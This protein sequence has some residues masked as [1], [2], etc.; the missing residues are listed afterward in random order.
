[1]KT[2]AN[3]TVLKSLARKITKENFMVLVFECAAFPV[4]AAMFDQNVYKY[5]DIGFCHEMV[6]SFL[7]ALPSNRRKVTFL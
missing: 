4:D 5:N 6:S 1:M 2:T 7:I 3:E